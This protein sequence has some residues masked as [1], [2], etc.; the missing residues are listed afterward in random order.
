VEEDTEE[1]EE[2]PRPPEEEEV[3]P[4]RIQVARQRHNEWVFHEED[5]SGASSRQIRR[6]LEKLYSQ[7]QVPLRRFPV[8][9]DGIPACVDE[10][11]VWPQELEKTSEYR[12]Q[13]LDTIEP[14]IKENEAL[15]AEVTF[16]RGRIRELEEQE[17]A[18]AAERAGKYC[19]QTLSYRSCLLLTLVSTE[20]EAEKT[21]MLEEVARLTAASDEAKKRKEK[22]ARE[23]EGK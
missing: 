12:Q 17:A 3:Q 18:S 20:A 22:L 15:K 14:T 6:T 19:P 4:Q 8:V 13:C 9:G 2:I 11:S 21:L 16:L 10:L 1:I 7:V 23:L 5:R